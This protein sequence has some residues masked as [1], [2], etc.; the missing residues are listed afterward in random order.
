[1]RRYRKLKEGEEE[2]CYGEGG[3][4]K[5][6]KEDELEKGKGKRRKRAKGSYEDEKK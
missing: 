3:I 2:K 1:M 5:R 4:R 6:E